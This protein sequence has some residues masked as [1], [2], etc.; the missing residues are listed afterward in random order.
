MNLSLTDIP[1]HPGYKVTKDGEVWSDI[2]H[3]W[4]SPWLQDGYY[5]VGFGR[6]KHYAVHRLVLET[7]I[8]PCPDGMEGCH[9]DGVRTNNHVDNLRWDSRSEN[10]KDKV[11]HGTAANLFD[12]GERH[13]QSKLTAQNVRTIVYLYRTG[14]F[15]Q[16]EIGNIYGVEQQT[17]SGIV[18]KKI[19]RHLWNA[20]DSRSIQVAGYAE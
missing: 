17:I 10:A 5:R 14:E 4:L 11:R 1:N 2:S 9:N 18:N 20:N 13:P 7:F 12:R 6:S 3:R 16:K 15:K 8:G 19:W